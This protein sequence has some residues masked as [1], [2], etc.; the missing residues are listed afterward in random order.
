MAGHYRRAFLKDGELKDG[1]TGD[2]LPQ[3]E[4]GFMR[5]R[6]LRRGYEEVQQAVAEAFTTETKLVSAG[7]P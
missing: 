5:L 3:P 2:L 4:P 6:P 7:E 1:M